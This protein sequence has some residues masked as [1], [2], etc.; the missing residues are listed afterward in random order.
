M[1]IFPQE[2]LIYWMYNFN[3]VFFLII[4]HLLISFFLFV[5]IYRFI[6]EYTKGVQSDWT[7][8]RLAHFKLRDFEN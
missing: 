8:N 4:I 7:I 1:K 5:F 6:R 2:C 3:I